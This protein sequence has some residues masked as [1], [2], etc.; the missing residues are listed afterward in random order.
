AQLYQSLEKRANALQAAYDELHR[1]D[2]VKDD[3][4]Q[5]I[6]HELQTPLHQVVMQLDLLAN[7]AFGSLNDEQRDNMGIII[8]K[9]TTVGELVRDMVSLH[10]LNTQKMRFGTAQ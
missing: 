7:E 3:L 9:I 5:N 4:I 2:K 10:T 8:N 1:A 6:S